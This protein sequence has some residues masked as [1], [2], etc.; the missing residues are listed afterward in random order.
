MQTIEIVYV[1]PLKEALCIKVECPPGASVT[2]ALTASN[3]YTL[4]PET[5]SLPF[6]IFSKKTTPDR[7]LSPGDRIEIYR[8]LV[9][10]PKEKRRHLARKRK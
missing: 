1:T 5:K 10:D 9:L 8:P 2:D 3:I 4:Y 6:G 7:I